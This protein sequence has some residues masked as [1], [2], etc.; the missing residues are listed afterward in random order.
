MLTYCNRYIQSCIQDQI[1]FVFS[2]SWHKTVG[3]IWQNRYCWV[4]FTPFGIPFC[5]LVQFYS[6]GSS[7]FIIRK[8]LV[9]KDFNNISAS[10]QN[11][12]LHEKKCNFYTHL[13]YCTE[14]RWLFIGSTAI[15]VNGLD[16]GSA[17]S[18][19]RTKLTSSKCDWTRIWAI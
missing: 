3:C 13:F 12:F 9:Q 11:L 15:W 17:A 6:R 18:R 14:I 4:S 7:S 5:L 8:W 10:F 2:V 19:A 16:T 1:F